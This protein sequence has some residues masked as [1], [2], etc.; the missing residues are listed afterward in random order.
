MD[1]RKVIQD[2]GIDISDVDIKNAFKSFDPQSQGEI[3]YDEFVKVLIG[4]MSTY[5]A[6]LAAKAFEKLDIN[7]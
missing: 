1:F 6:S 7:Q 3:E 5:R 2:S 4:P